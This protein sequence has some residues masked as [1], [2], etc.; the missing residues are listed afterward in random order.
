MDLSLGQR[1]VD[2]VAEV[3]GTGEIPHV[4]PACLKIDLDVGARGGERR[5]A[6]ERDA[7]GGK[8]NLLLVLPVH[9]GHRDVLQ[10]HRPTI[11]GR[12][13]TLGTREVL[14]ADP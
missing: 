9:R 10:K 3:D 14:G 2:G 8:R 13:G 6:V 7:R 4:D 5:R 12:D 1:G 11:R